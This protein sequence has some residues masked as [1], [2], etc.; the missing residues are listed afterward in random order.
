MKD[1]AHIVFSWA[2]SIGKSKS[3]VDGVLFINF[4]FTTLIVGC[5]LKCFAG[6]FFLLCL[7]R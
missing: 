5:Y 1:K 7:A 3:Q 4:P 2:G 6:Y